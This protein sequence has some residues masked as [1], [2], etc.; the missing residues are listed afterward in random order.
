MV[1]SLAVMSP[2]G[3]VGAVVSRAVV[4]CYAA[5]KLPQA[6]H[7]RVKVILLNN[8]YERDNE[9]QYFMISKLSVSGNSSSK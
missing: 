7:K 9:H 6:M 2:R 4:S 3:I 5:S 1:K 8:G